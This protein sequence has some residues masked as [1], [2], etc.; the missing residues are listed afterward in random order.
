M[1]HGNR[2]DATVGCT[3]CV[4]DKIIVKLLTHCLF[5]IHQIAMR[6]VS[7]FLGLLVLTSSCHGFLFTQHVTHVHHHGDK[8]YHVSNKQSTGAHSGNNF[9]GGSGN[10]NKV[11]LPEDNY[12]RAGDRQVCVTGCP[13]LVYVQGQR[14]LVRL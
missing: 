10:I 13:V 11:S 8:E 2:T 6:K 4:T 9:H 5:S 12:P 14:S 1:T 3:K 7:L